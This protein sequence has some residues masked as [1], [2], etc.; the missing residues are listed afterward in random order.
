MSEQ[1]QI[2]FQAV[3]NLDYV[4]VCILL[5]EFSYDISNIEKAINLTPNTCEIIATLN[6]YKKNLLEK[7]QERKVERYYTNLVEFAILYRKP[8]IVKR[9]PDYESRLRDW[10]GNICLYNETTFASDI[11]WIEQTFFKDEEYVKI[12]KTYEVNDQLYQRV[13]YKHYGIKL[14]PNY[15]YHK[16]Y[17]VEQQQE[18]LRA[19]TFEYYLDFP[20]HDL[21]KKSKL[22][23]VKMCLTT[24]PDKWFVSDGAGK[25][26][27]IEMKVNNV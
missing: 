21:D 8:N 15:H 20:A 2:L 3:V 12:V 10:I 11:K 25:M 5:E 4:V 9:L 17:T 13:S 16:M 7:E 18:E 19:L 22:I 26:I 6:T 14:S 27:P 23:E 24:K 1:D